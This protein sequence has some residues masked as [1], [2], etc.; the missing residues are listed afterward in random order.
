MQEKQQH[1]QRETKEWRKIQ[2]R[3]L[4]KLRSAQHHLLFNVGAYLA[5]SVIEFYLAEVGHSQTTG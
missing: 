3:E 4:N 1:L 2:H 5:I